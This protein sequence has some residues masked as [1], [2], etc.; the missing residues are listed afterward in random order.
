NMTSTWLC[1]RNDLIANAAV[2]A[3]AAAVWQLDS[4]WPDVIVGVA[5][6][7]LFLRTAVEVI[8]GA[9]IELARADEELTQVTG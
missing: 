6:A 9:R 7:L 1:S 5:I 8:R 3:A 2:L 4:A